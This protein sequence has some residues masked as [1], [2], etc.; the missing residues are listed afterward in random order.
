MYSHGDHI[1]EIERV[2]LGHSTD[3]DPHVV[4][5]WRRCLDRYRLNPAEAREA[6]ILPSERLKEHRQQAE[7]LITIARSGL[8]CLY[9]QVAGQAYVLLLADRRGV[10]VDF[11]GDPLFDGNL[12]KAGLYLGSKWTEDLSGTCAVG[13]CLATGEALTIHQTD[14][15]DTMHTALS[16]T[17]AP[18]YDAGGELSAVL[19]ISL[20]SSPS[21]KTSQNL[22]LHLV[23]A[24]ARRIELAHLMAGTRNQW[25]LRFS[26]SPEFIEVD[27]EAA[28]AIDDNGRITG[29]TNGGARV[30][31]RAIG[32]DW[33]DPRALIGKPVSRFLDLGIDDFPDLTRG[34]ATNERIVFARDGDRLFAHA[35]EPKPAQRTVVARA[36][37][38][39]I[40][41]LGD[42]TPEMAALQHKAAK[43][44]RTGLPIL[45]Q[46]ETGTGK[47]HLARAIH[48]DSGRAGRFV[49]INC[50]A[51]PETLIESELFGY[52]AGAFTGA[53][54]K[55]RKGLIEQ[56]DGGTLFLDE[57]G[58]MPMML[59][60]RLLRV[61]AEREVQPVGA[62][63]PRPVN[64]RVLSASHRPLP[65]L[66]AK[67]VFR[68]DLYYRLCAATLRLPPLR[69]RA[70][71]DWLLSRLLD[72]HRTGGEP[73]DV[74]PAAR[75]ALRRHDWPGNIR[76]LDNV[77]SVAL[78]LSECGTI[79]IDDLPDGFAGSSSASDSGDAGGRLRSLLLACNGNVSEAAR[80]LGVDRTTVHRQMRRYGIV[81]GN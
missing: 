1:R 61:L 46:G 28:I 42:K 34:R 32:G 29:M 53:A 60:G 26:R 22:A 51:I 41:N 10:T 12:R 4:E 71:F 14:H 59:Q 40:R 6:V 69:E 55:G 39:A 13:S 21:V 2:G 8:E 15:F 72:R 49:A 48:H 24:A 54:P 38:A 78:A 35:I 45:I 70:D 7:E 30:L 18:I 62:A 77:L 66:V 64:I 27:P 67:G 20:L 73:V 81:A 68:E 11:I 52:A 79:D 44:S 56:A 76:E 65:E 31:A 23:K 57:I 43:L 37:P 5:S 25:V 33:R 3:R 74:T 63:T 16:C 17:A 47:E 80:R 9:R 19:D 36:L 75:V 50:A 58:D